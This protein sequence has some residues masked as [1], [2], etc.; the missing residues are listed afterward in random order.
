MFNQLRTKLTLVNIGVIASL[1]LLLIAGTYYVSRVNTDRQSAELM[2]AM[3][4]E[5][6]SGKRQPF[7]PRPP[8]DPKPPVFSVKVSPTG[9]ITVENSYSNFTPD[10]LKSL[11]KST[12]DQP[13]SQGRVSFQSFQLSYYRTDLPNAGGQL[14]LFQDV[15]RERSAQHTVLTSLSVIGFLCLVLSMVGSFFMANRALFPI[16]EAWQQQ[17]DF[18]ADA[19]HELRTPLT[20][21][22]TSLEALRQN[23][24]ETVASQEEWV[25]NIEEVTDRM[26]RLVDSLLFLARTDANQEGLNYNHFSLADAL[27]DS[28]DPM[29]TI[30]RAKDV[31]LELSALPAAPFL[32]DMEQI[33]RLVTILLDNAIRHTPA[34]GT[35]SLSMH[36]TSKTATI[37]VRDT[38][39]GIGPEHIERIFDRFYQVDQ[40]RSQGGVGLGLSMAKLI[41]EKHNGT[42]KVESLLGTGST[43]IVELPLTW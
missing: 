9:H 23:E 33:K 39:E 6:I 21:I 42:I 30:A 32:G 29:R 20:V 8:M 22:R 5:I 37:A 3:A 4:Q 28:A 36:R 7:E 43:F 25:T 15:G 13:K 35:V 12:I 2:R 40:A 24:N 16:K 11:V 38:G 19:S 10:Q 26:G 18:V 17:K 41:A 1:F 34:G 31:A 27:Y 14:L